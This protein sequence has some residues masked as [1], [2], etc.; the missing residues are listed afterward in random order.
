VS[1]SLLS[2]Q[3]SPTYR[4]ADSQI[5]LLALLGEEQH[6]A[7]AFHPPEYVAWPWPALVTEE[8]SMTQTRRQLPQLGQWSSLDDLVDL[9]EKQ[10]PQAMQ[11]ASHSPFYQRTIRGRTLPTTVAELAALP[12]TTKQDLRDNYPFGM[13]AVAKS[14]LATY[15]ESSGTAGEPTPS[16]YTAEDWVDLAERYARKSVGLLPTDVFMVRAP[17]ALPL[18]G[19]LAHAAGRLNGAFIVPADARSSAMPYS[20]VIR[21]LHD[22]EVTVTWSMPT[23]VLLWAAAARAAGYQPA[24]DFPALRGLF[25]GGEPLS[26]ARRRRMSAVWGGVPIVEEYGSTETGSLAGECTEGRLH[27]WADRVIPEVLD[28]ATGKSSPEGSGQ[29]VVTTLYREAMPLIRYNLEDSVEVSYSECACG[30]K[31]PT[32]RVLGRTAFGYPVNGTPVMQHRLED[33]VF[34]LPDEYEVLFWRAKAEA[35][36][37]LIEIEVDPSK[38]DAACAALRASIH[39][40]FG[41]PC[42]VVHVP[43]GTLVPRELLVSDPAIVKPRSLFGPEEDWSKAILYG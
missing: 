23:E 37:L 33:L 30:W 39:A 1:R 18:T 36:R 34:E 16:Y 8:G 29:L 12:L 15:H 4:D 40:E 3:P 28:P 19:H 24:K 6:L 2:R 41:V 27:L 5:T 7:P 22:L 31:T 25:V 13:L 21:V 26:M 20:R 14:E 9:Q 35:A 10:L 32:I 42:E 43:P 38:A 17:Y 11:W